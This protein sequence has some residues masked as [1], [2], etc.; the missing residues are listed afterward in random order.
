AAGC[1]TRSGGFGESWNRCECSTMTFTISGHPCIR[2]T[3]ADPLPEM[4]SCGDGVCASD[5]L[6]RTRNVVIV[7]ISIRI[8]RDGIIDAHPVLTASMARLRFE[9][10]RLRLSTRIVDARPLPGAADLQAGRL[11]ARRH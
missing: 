10:A 11:R 3:V 9:V 6:A 5:A 8:R 1:S 7:R 4:A 2:S